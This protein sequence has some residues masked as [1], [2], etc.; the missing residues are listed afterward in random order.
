M[1]NTAEDQSFNNINLQTHPFRFKEFE[2]CRFNNCNFARAGLSNFRFVECTFTDCDLSN[3]KL[4]AT[5]L[6]D[7]H[8]VNCKLL[9]LHFQ[10]CSEFLF[11]VAFENSVLNFSSFY[12]RQ[13][14]KTVFKNTLLQEVDFTD[15]NL[16]GAVFEKCDLMKAVF[17][18]TV[19]EKADFRTAIN[20]SIDPERNKVKKAKFD[21]L[22][23]T[24]LLGKYDIEVS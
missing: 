17:D 8:F 14:K 9:G 23:L 20:Y 7:I 10:D 12:G 22:G 4:G 13:L 15:A 11:S 6:N 24:G 18:N 16:A 5:T 3:A 1:S 19:L 2:C 21:R